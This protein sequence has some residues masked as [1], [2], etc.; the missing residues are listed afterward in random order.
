[1][2][3]SRQQRIGIFLFLSFASGRDIL[4]G[5]FRYART[6]GRWLP[7]LVQMP[8][9]LTPDIREQIAG[10]AFDGFIASAAE[11]GGVPGY[12]R[13]VDRPVTVIGAPC[14]ATADAGRPTAY[15]R[16]DD[17]AIG[18]LAAQTLARTGAFRAFAYVPGGCGPR[19]NA[20]RG[21]GFL[22]AAAPGVRRAVFPQKA[23]PDSETDRR[24]L[25]EWLAALPKPAALLAETDVRASQVLASCKAA[26]VSV[27]DEI[28]VVGVDNDALICDAT[29]PPLT[30][31]IPDHERIGF[32][33]AQELE[34]LLRRRAGGRA[35]VTACP[36]A[37]VTACP[38]AVTA[39]PPAGVAVRDSTR[40]V[41]PAARLIDRATAF[42]AR[43]AAHAVR[44]ADVA[45]ALHVSRRLLE[46]RFAQFEHRSLAAT[47][48]RE[49][50]KR[51]RRAL[52]ETKRPI[53]SVAQDLGFENVNSLRN[54]FRRHY[55]T[56]MSAFRRR[57]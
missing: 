20:D 31:V 19:W 28:A 55:G 16:T 41:S 3:N 23:P 7:Q 36:P 48:L 49:R 5:I 29:P 1:M 21:K 27:P 22:N 13:G 35:A 42:I 47:I 39:C 17:A 51:V 57:T 15:V 46:M 12:L 44:P 10:G 6:R 9:Y 25:R 52:R 18:R 45:A 34:R 37:D 30:S 2:R 32:L 4:S 50:L 38:P 24:R 14:N 56:T 11:T 54:T 43:E 40:A 8:D 33:A 26:G 53:A